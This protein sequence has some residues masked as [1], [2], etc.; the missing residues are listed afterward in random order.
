MIVDGV[1]IQSVLLVAETAE[2]YVVGI[3][4][5]LLQLHHQ[6]MIYLTHMYSHNCI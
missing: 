3:M 5:S 6:M 4:L 1:I 2:F